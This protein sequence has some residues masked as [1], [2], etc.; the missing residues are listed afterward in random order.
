MLEYLATDSKQPPRAE[1]TEAVSIPSY[2]FDTG[3]KPGSE[4]VPA[5][6]AQRAYLRF[7]SGPVAGQ[8]QN[9]DRPLISIGDP[10]SY[11]AAVSQRT[12][13]YYLLNLG[14]GL[15]VKLNDEPVHGAAAM[16]ENGDLITLGEHRIEVKIFDQKE[17]S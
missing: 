15:F 9:I 13:G 10:E 2:R 5:P 14:K 12:N 3:G 4:S 7:I 8:I 16:L 6:S 1:P 11:Y 17:T